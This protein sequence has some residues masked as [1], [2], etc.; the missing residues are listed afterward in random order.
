VPPENLNRFNVMVASLGWDAYV[1]ARIL[2][3]PHFPAQVENLVQSVAASIQLSEV[4][5]QLSSNS[6][7]NSLGA[8]LLIADG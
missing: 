7:A 1:D 8:I 5:R 3:P 6:L 2:D 4:T